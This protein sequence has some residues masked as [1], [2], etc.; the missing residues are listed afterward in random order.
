MWRSVLVCPLMKK[1]RKGHI[2]KVR[3]MGFTH[4]L[5]LEAKAFALSLEKLI[6]NLSNLSLEF[7]FKLR[8][9]SF[10]VY[11]VQNKILLL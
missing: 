1:G 5:M 9:I 8:F 7:L 3:P 11:F 6:V 2:W 10:C 4:L